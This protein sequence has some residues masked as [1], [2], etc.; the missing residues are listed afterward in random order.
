MDGFRVVF[1]AGAALALLGVAVA[2]GRTQWPRVPRSDRC[3]RCGREN[4]V[5]APSRAEAEWFTVLI[6]VL[7]FVFTA[8]VLLAVAALLMLLALLFGGSDA[9]AS[10]WVGV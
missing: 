2:A 7:A 1:A 3:P 9:G 8:T 10:L 6:L 5:R 4:I